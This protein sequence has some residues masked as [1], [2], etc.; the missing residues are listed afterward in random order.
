MSWVTE[1]QKLQKHSNVKLVYLT[2]GR[3]TKP[4][5]NE[6]KCLPRTQGQCQEKT[7]RLRYQYNKR[8]S[9]LLKFGSQIIFSSK[10]QWMNEY[11]VA[12]FVTL[13]WPY[14]GIYYDKIMVIGTVDSTNKKN[15]IKQ[16]NEQTATEQS[17]HQTITANHVNV[18]KWVF[19]KQQTANSFNVTDT[20]HR[21]LE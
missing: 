19:V 16:K 8:Q 4:N 14:D 12:L 3:V 11:L 1:Q 10:Y 6:I 15:H 17:A 7:D 13:T 21:N 20:H 5:P 2:F 9:Y 18:L